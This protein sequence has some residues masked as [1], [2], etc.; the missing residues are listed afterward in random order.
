MAGILR[1][2]LAIVLAILIYFW[3]NFS[4]ADIEIF[5]GYQSALYIIDRNCSLAIPEFK[6][7]P[8]TQEILQKENMTIISRKEVLLP[9]LSRYFS[10]EIRKKEFTKR[11]FP[12]LRDRFHLNLIQAE[13]IFD[14]ASFISEK[15]ENK[16]S[17][18]K[19]SAIFNWLMSNFQLREGYTSIPSNLLLTLERKE[20]NCNELSDVMEA[21]LI[22][23]GIQTRPIYGLIFNETKKKFEFHRWLEVYYPDKGWFP[24]DLAGTKHFI[25]TD[26]IILYKGEDFILREDLSYPERV[27]SAIKLLKK[28]D[29]MLAVDFLPLKG[30]LIFSPREDQVQY[31]SSITGKFLTIKPEIVKGSYIYLKGENIFKK[32]ILKGDSFSFNG[33][34]EGRY[35]LFFDT[36]RGA[37]M[38]EI[39]LNRNELKTII[40]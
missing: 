28:E 21:M 7:P 23:L 34:N 22:S 5:E 13:E 18:K 19:V 27:L 40:F 30:R 26:H 32:S 39:R 3:L 29:K 6:T 36:E 11:V 24:Y 31:F 2:K 16:T 15:S 38:R 35:T 8:S 1:K 10:P 20:G 37:V 4:F 17:L 12:H 9:V 25:S 14:L 33:L